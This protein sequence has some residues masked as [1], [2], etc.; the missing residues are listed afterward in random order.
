MVYKTVNWV[1][2][3]YTATDGS[4][5]EFSIYVKLPGWLPY[6]VPGQPANTLL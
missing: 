1:A 6:L 3:A 4:R 5:F 2:L